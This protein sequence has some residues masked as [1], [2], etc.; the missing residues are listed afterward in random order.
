MIKDTNHTPLSWTEFMRV[1][2]RTGTITEAELFAAAKKPAYKIT[3]DFGALGTRKTSAQLTKRYTPEE[4]VGQQVVAVVNFPPKQIA[5]IM[6]ECL[7]LGAIGEENEVTLL[8]P[9][10]KVANGL[11][12]G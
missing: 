5:T 10:K 7:L 6:S 9:G 4:L 8:H 12:I 3:V 1:D 11:R 2:I